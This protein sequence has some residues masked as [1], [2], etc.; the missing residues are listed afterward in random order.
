MKGTRSSVNLNNLQEVAQSGGDLRKGLAQYLTP[1]VIAERVKDKL[2]DY[3]YGAKPSSLIDP[4]SGERNLLSP[5]PYLTPQFGVDIQKTRIDYRRQIAG[6]CRKFGEVIEELF[7]HLI[8]DC[9]VANYPFGLPWKGMKP[10][11]WTWDFLTQHTRYGCMIG[12]INEVGHLSDSDNVWH[13]ETM[14]WPDANVEVML[15]FY[16]GKEKQMPT[17]LGELDKAFSQIGEIIAEEQRQIPPYNVWLKD[18][19]VAGRAG[20]LGV[21]LS[22]RYRVKHKLTYADAKRLMK[23]DGSTPQVLAVDRETRVLL[24]ELICKGIYKIE[25][26]ASEAIQAA[27]ED[28]SRESTPIMPVTD[29][30]R[31]AYL[32]DESHVT[33]VKDWKGFKKG[34]TYPVQSKSYT[35]TQH[36]E[37]LKPHFNEKTGR[38]ERIPHECTLSGQDKMIIINGPGPDEVRFMSNPTLSNEVDESM[39]WDLFAR[40]KVQTVTERFPNEV[41][42]I[43]NRLEAME[44]VSDFNFFSGQVEYLSRVLV[45]DNGL[46]AAETGTGKSLYAIA[47]Y[48]AKDASRCLIVCPKGTVAGGRD[49]DLSQWVSEI[50]RF[51]P[52]VE[53]FE[54][55]THDDYRRIRGLNGGELPPGFYVTYYDAFF[56]NGGAVENCSWANAET[57]RWGDLKLWEMVH[58]PCTDKKLRDE[59]DKQ[60][61]D[62][63][64]VGDEVNG[65]RC[66]AKPSLSTLIGHEFDMVCLDEAHNIKTLTANRT[67][68]AIRLPAKYRYAFTATPVPN[69]ASDIF[70]IMGWVC[71]PDWYK[72]DICN[73]AWPFRRE[74]FARFEAIFLS[75][76][77][78]WTA[79]TMI[80]K[81]TGKSRKVEKTSPVLSSPARLLKILK[82]SIAYITKAQ[83]NM[84]YL[85]PRIVDIRVPLG[86]KQAKLYGHFAELSNIHTTI[87]RRPVPNALVRA[88]AQIEW[89]RTICTDPAHASMQAQMQ[90]VSSM[91]PKVMAILE[92]VSECLER[93]EQVVIVNAR[94][95]ISDL[96][97]TKLEEAG[98][99]ISRIDSSSHS[100]N[101]SEESN[102]F[103]RGHT[104]V[105]LI[106]IKCAVGHSF[107][108][109]RNL[110]VGSLEYSPG[111]FEQARGRVDRLTSQESRIYCILCKDTIEEVMFDTV[112][113]KDDASKIILKG[114]RVPRDF[115][116]VDMSE[117]VMDSIM[118]WGDGK[119]ETVDETDCLMAWETLKKRLQQ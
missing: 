21:N 97:Q 16:A 39:I 93:G 50:N 29:F 13:S 108:Q 59:L 86:T 105:M 118:K 113:L 106:G 41:A 90:T 36:F 56:T 31:V 79:E 48:V 73:A 63:I 78:D 72:G 10:W 109:C 43:R 77:R 119:R 22:A 30:E 99:S 11:Q 62:I 6:D 55:F 18:S 12:A 95:G 44:I 60:T 88:G 84:D 70:S 82:P 2:L 51:A 68:A 15:L 57:P 53:V 1:P 94:I 58:G 76:E 81:A 37:R 111:P 46:I 38:V 107:D 5:W 110:I 8:W 26:R 116:P 98:V 23:L 112:A 33:C 103:K 85:P 47:A 61:Q 52:F 20:S 96:I 27:L 71:V 92:L 74:D 115:V 64:T 54:M 100:G 42:R 67:Q 101:H 34:H 45:R 83:C 80:Q 28:A 32:D 3:R 17:P 14:K 89:L 19:V 25:P 4:Q 24:H 7:P 65:I 91:N 69:I 75:K 9:G 117:V 102:L 104:Q 35:F 40:P 49:E 66:I 87:T 114:Q